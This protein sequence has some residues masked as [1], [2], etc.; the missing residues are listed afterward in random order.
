MI[1]KYLALIVL[2]CCSVPAFAERID[3]DRVI[4]K[5]EPE[6]ERAMLEGKI[7]SATVALVS[8]H[9]IIWAKG[10]GY[11][12]LWA[13]TPAVPTTGYLMGSTFKPMANVA[14]LQ[15]ME[16]GKFKL[17]D[18]VNDYLTDFKI[19][20]EIPSNPITFR[21]VL[22]HTSGLPSPTGFYPLWGDTLPPPLAKFLSANLEVKRAPLEKA[23]YSNLGFTLV[24]YLVEKLSG[25]PFKEY[26]RKN[27]WD[28]LEMTD[29]MFD[30]TPDL[31]ERLAIPYGIDEKTGRNVPMDRVKAD[32][33][34]AGI[35]YGTIL[36]QAN[37]LITSLNGGEFKGKRII[38]AETL[39]EAYRR[40]YDKFL[41]PTDYGWGN[42]TT[43]YGLSWLI[44][45]RKGERFFGHTGSGP[46]HTSF[47]L[48]NID[49]KIGF[50]IMTNGTRAH[51][52]VSR[53]GDLALDLLSNR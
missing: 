2:I 9:K 19:R 15:L 24:G 16:K 3:L 31:Q 46:G 48:G 40:Q 49:R 51:A 29:T 5:L 7:P 8:G 10:F 33:W 21:H 50:A 26:M 14:I 27:V 13:R 44:T 17:D 32:I 12:N 35:V 25:M 18:R 6:I 23:E 53:L 39:A 22:S 30:P 4:A 45:Q 1:R 36:N 41:G 38:K 37:F 52:Y 28:P 11:S 34:P 42:E 43:G 20:G 47:L